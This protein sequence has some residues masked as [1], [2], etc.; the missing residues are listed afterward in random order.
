MGQFLSSLVGSLVGPRE[1]RILMLGLD[2]AGKTTVLYKLKLGEKVC[3]IPTI[4]F[5]LETVQYKNINFTMWDVGGQDKI[6]ALWRHYFSG[7]QGL[8]FVVDSADM[9]RIR[10][11]RDELH[12]LI[13]DPELAHVTLLVLANKMDLPQAMNVAEITDKL[14]LTSLRQTS[15]YIQ[16]CCATSGQGLYEGLDW[17]GRALQ[18]VAS[19]H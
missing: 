17:L 12:G 5:N 2:A 1:L 3:T 16:S 4:G 8:I 11:A 14:Q 13:N 10:Q 9:E 19:R 7:T 15:W 6:R 18:D